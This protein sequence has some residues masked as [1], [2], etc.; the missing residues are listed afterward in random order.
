[1]TFIGPT[2][3]DKE[4]VEKYMTQGVVASDNDLLF[5][6]L[7]SDVPYVFGVVVVFA[8]L[9]LFISKLQKKQKKNISSISSDHLKLGGLGK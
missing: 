6:K 2:D 7:K 8:I 3:K 5:V 9:A 4:I 1:M